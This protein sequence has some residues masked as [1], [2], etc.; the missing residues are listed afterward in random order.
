[1]IGIGLFSSL[2]FLSPSKLLSSFEN[3]E[4]LKAEGHPP[5]STALIGQF[6]MGEG[7]PGES[8][9]GRSK[10]YAKRKFGI[11]GSMAKAKKLPPPETAKKGGK[12]DIVVKTNLSPDKLFKLAATT[13]IKN[14]TKKNK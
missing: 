8:I 6:A 14:R 10:S 12:Y 5:A 3:T 13:P 2:I 11:L 1:M 7:I 9:A 4:N